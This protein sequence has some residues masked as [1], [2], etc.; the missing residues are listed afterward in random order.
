MS[1]HA[2]QLAQALDQTPVRR[3]TVAHATGDEALRTLRAGHFHS[4]AG[5]LPALT[6]ALR[7]AAAGDTVLWIHGPQPQLYDEQHSPVALLKELDRGVRLVGYRVE[8]GTNAIWFRFVANPNCGFRS[9]AAGL[10]KN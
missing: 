10:P 4:G 5:N 2:P 7:T 8:P 3:I 1:A 6:Q 9:F